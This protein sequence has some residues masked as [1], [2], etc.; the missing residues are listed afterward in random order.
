MRIIVVRVLNETDIDGGVEYIQGTFEHFE[1]DSYCE[2]DN[3]KKG[4]YMVYVEWDWQQ[5]VKPHMRVFNIGSYGPNVVKYTDFTDQN[6]KAKFLSAAFIAKSK[7]TKEGLHHI[8]MAE[9]L[10]PKIDR[11]I[12]YG[13]REG[14]IYIIIENK[15]EEA[16]Y[17]EG[18]IFEKFENLTFVDKEGELAG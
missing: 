7:R 1:K 11:Y 4:T 3:L 15:D 8:N 14:Y 18:I 13:F 6:N 16:I 17:K 5:V 2:C 9:H 12:E 10:A